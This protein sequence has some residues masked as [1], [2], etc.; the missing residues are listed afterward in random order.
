VKGSAIMG[1]GLLPLVISVLVVSLFTQ[2]VA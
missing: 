2:G 1:Y